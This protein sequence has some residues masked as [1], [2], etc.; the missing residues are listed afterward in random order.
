M[1]K[2]QLVVQVVLPVHPSLRRFDH[3]RQEVVNGGGGAF[4]RQ[5][6]A[7]QRLEKFAATELARRQRL[8]H[9]FNKGVALGCQVGEDRVR[10]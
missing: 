4:N 1:Q 6:E 5:V 9:F 8:H 3:H 2:F 10:G 7:I